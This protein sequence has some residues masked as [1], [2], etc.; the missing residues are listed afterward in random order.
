MAKIS[1]ISVII[2]EWKKPDNIGLFVLIHEVNIKY[3][4]LFNF[5][6]NLAA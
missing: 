3:G 4:F 6:I 5:L 2:N 1:Q